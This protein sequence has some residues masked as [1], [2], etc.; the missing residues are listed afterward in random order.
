MRRSAH[1][2]RCL[3]LALYAELL[4][5]PARTLLDFASVL[6]DTYMISVDRH[7]IGR[8]FD[9]WGISRKLIKRK[10]VAKFSN[11]NILYT[12][13]YLNFVLGVRNW[14]H[15]KFADEASFCSK[16]SCCVG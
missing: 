8:T 4:S 14:T 7:F 11:A 15:I 12:S 10:N 6:S 3:Q 1:C 16:G 2:G 5:N 13:R 9:R